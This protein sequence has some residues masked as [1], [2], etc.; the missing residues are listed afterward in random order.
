MRGKGQDIGVTKLREGA[1]E[2]RYVISKISLADSEN[3]RNMG[4]AAKDT[5]FLLPLSLRRT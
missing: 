1:D 2:Q 5:V 4:E 3:G